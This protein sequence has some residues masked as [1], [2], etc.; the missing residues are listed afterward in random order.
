MA[1]AFRRYRRSARL[2][3]LRLQNAARNSTEWF[4][5][6][7]RYLHLDPEQFVY[8]LL[9]RSQ[10]IS[11]ENLRA[12]R[13]DLARERRKLVRA[14]RRPGSAPQARGR[15]CSRRSSARRRAEEPHRRVADGAVSR[16]RRRP[17]DYHLVHFGERAGRRRAG[18]H[19]DD[20][21]V[22]GRPHHARL[23]RAV[24]REHKRPGN[25]SSISSMPRPTPRSRMQLGHAGAKGST[26]LGWE[27][28][29]PAA[30]RRAIGR[31]RR[32]RRSPWTPVTRCRAR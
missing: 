11:H 30:A 21:R 25:A 27:D 6:V 12:A 23:P 10:R 18:V 28:D 2:E 5:N 7:E 29:R 16:R 15:R 20:L 24:R 22:A 32:R 1:A 3:V 4:E 31:Y 14:S 19:G 13:R 17:S 26:Q 9:T 8:S